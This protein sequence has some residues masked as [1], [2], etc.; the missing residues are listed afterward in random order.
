MQP[1]KVCT[2][3]GQAWG[4]RGHF[5]AD[6]SIRLA[7]YMA[8]FKALELGLLLF[9]HDACGRPWRSR[10][11]TSRTSPMGRSSPRA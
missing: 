10:P 11:A 4:A 1:F 8:N 9:N 2:L 3:C 5:L 6:P 7:G